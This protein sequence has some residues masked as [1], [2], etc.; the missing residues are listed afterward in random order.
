MY[1]I[2]LISDHQ[3]AAA[4]FCLYAIL[5]IKALEKQNF[6]YNLDYL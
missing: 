2:T 3:V 4:L 6:K 1:L 5:N